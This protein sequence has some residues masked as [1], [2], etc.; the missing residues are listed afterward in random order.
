MYLVPSLRLPLSLITSWKGGIKKKMVEV[1]LGDTASR[2]CSVWLEN[3]N[4]KK[5]R[6]PR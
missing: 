1:K 6:S 5:I 3:G 4:L 2:L